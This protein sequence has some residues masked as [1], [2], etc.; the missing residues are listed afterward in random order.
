MTSIKKYNGYGEDLERIMLLRSSPLAVK[1]LESEKDVPEGAVRP[2][3]DNGYHLAQCQ[4][5]TVSRRKRQSIAMLKEDNWCFA[6]L[7]AYGMVDK[8]D[9]PGLEKIMAFPCLERGKYAGIVSAP[10]KTAN[11]EPDLI[12]IYCNPAQLRNVL[13]P[14]HFRDEFVVN[15][16]FFPPV[17]SYAVVPV[18]ENGQFMVSLPDPGEAERAMPADDEI[19]LS[20]PASKLEAL[21]NGVKEFD[22]RKTGYM[23]SGA[24]MMPDF[25]RPEFYQN[26]FKRWGLDTE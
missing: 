3:R 4:A 16:H 1:L 18:L 26:L 21:V 8:P 23:Y 13:Y 20:F 22:K 5:F 24:E 15:S 11:F 9:D 25:P 17:C 10:L 12:I 2:K 7:I 14:S 19:I 6:P